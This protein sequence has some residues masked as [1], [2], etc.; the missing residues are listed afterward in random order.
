[1]KEYSYLKIKCLKKTN[2]MNTQKILSLFVLSVFLVSTASA[3]MVSDG[4]FKDGSQTLEIEKGEDA[5]FEVDFTTSAYPM[6]ISVKMYNSN[7]QLVHTFLDSSA[8]DYFAEGIYEIVKSTY[9]KLGNYEIRI[10]GSDNAG[11]SD[12]TILYLKVVEEGTEP[13]E[14]TTFPEVTILS[15]E[16]GKTYTSHIE[17]LHY[18]IYDKNIDYCEYST[19]NGATIN[20]LPCKNGENTYISLKSKLGTNKWTIYAT[21]KSGNQEIKTISFYIS[22]PSED[23]TAP[24]I[25]ILSPEDKEYKTSTIALK[26][27]TNEDAEVWFKI[28]YK[29][30]VQ[31]NNPEDHIYTN[32]LK[33][34]NGEHKITFYAED[35]AGNEAE[36]SITFSVDTSDSDNGKNNNAINNRYYEDELDREA[37]LNQFSAKTINVDDSQ[38]T[39]GKTSNSWIIRLIVGLIVLVVLIIVISMLRA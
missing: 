14:D 37:Y 20:D 33:V 16:S 39:S 22:I 13:G 36:K 35:D 28:D 11:D 31:M 21:D 6:D 7:N 1:M 29:E 5:I 10:S 18:K 2:K 3:L 15:P 19:N 9:E 8:E 25:T 30:K 24:I 34:S 12:E 27:I 32:T 17:E 38:T 23:I 4:Q 26:I